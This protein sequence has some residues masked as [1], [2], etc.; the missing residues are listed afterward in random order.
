MPSKLFYIIFF[1]V[2]IV[3]SVKFTNFMIKKIKLNRWIIGFSAFLVLIVPSFLFNKIN[4][5]IWNILLIASSVLCIMFFEITRQML[6][7]DEYKGIV[8]IAN[9]KNK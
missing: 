8:K 6:E 5:V 4:P 9:K 2:L 7:K 1:I 3:G